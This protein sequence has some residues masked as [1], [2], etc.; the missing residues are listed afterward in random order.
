[1]IST[2]EQTCINKKTV[3]YG[4]KK[5]A[6]DKIIHLQRLLIWVDTFYHTSS[7]LSIRRL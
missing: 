1:M 2:K 7:N 6:P 5:N 3:H 4:E